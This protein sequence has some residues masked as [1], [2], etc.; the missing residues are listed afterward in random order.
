M[1]G[2]SSNSQKVEPECIELDDDIVVL[3]ER[4]PKRP[5]IGTSSSLAIKRESSP[6]PEDPRTSTNRQG[7]SSSSILHGSSNLPNSSRNMKP[8]GNEQQLT[9]HA[10]LL[11]QLDAHI[12]AAINKGEMVERKLLDALLAAIN[13]QV[14]KDPHSVRK[15]ILEKQLILPNSISLPPS[16]VFAFLFLIYRIFL[17]FLSV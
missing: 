13:I 10:S 14:Q 7:A 9:S 17:S 2:T 12:G 11:D 4:P 15:L 5:K 3:D 8:K 6:V 1:L 16:Q